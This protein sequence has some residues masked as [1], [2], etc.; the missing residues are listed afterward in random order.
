[1]E[2]VRTIG[3][4]DH[5]NRHRCQILHEGQEVLPIPESAYMP[6]EFSRQPPAWPSVVRQAYSHNRVFTAGGVTPAIE[7]RFAF[8]GLS[9]II[10]VA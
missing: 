8:S 9:G 10:L 2:W 1:M 6:V 5:R 3:S 7:A 4:S